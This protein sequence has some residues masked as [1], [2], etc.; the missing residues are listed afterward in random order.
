MTPIK[1][2]LEEWCSRAQEHIKTEEERIRTFQQF[3]REVYL[4]QGISR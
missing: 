1:V 4:N 3:Y 2:I